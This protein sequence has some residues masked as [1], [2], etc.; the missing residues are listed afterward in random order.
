MIEL[1]DSTFDEYI[2]SAESPVI[3]DFWASWCQP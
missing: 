1:T 3:V 2:A